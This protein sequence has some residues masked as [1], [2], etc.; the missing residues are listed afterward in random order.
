MKAYAWDEIGMEVAE[1]K[2]LDSIQKSDPKETMI[3]LDYEIMRQIGEQ[4][5]NATFSHSGVVNSCQYGIGRFGRDKLVVYTLGDSRAEIDQFSEW[6]GEL[7]DDPSDDEIGDYF[8][9]I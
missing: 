3:L 8:E 9:S 5:G 1:F 6:I 2:V 4:D 7:E